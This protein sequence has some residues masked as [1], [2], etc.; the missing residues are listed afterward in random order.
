MKNIYF[1][2]A[3]TTPMDPDVLEAMLPF[4]T[5]DFGNASSGTHH[6]GSKAKAAVNYFRKKI[7]N[8]INAEEGEI[9]FNSG[10]TEGI[11]TILKGVFDRYHTKGKHIISCKTEHKA[12][13]DCLDYLS[14]IGAEITYISVNSNGMINLQELEDSIRPDT[15]LISFLFINNETGVVFPVEKIGELAEQKKTLFFCDATQA[16]GKTTVDV[17]KIKAAA[18]VFSAHKING[19]K[20]VG[21]LY[22]SRKNPRISFTPLLHGGSQEKQLRPGTL[23]VP[24]IVG[25]AKAVE[26][27]PENNGG[28]EAFS[29]SIVNHLTNNGAVI[30]GRKNGSLFNQ[31]LIP[32]II[33][34]QLPSIK[35]ARLIQLNPNFAFSLGSACNSEQK[36]P[37]HVLTAM[38]L[39]KKEIESSFRISIGK[40]TTKEEVEE[41]IQKFKI[42]A[43]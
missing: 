14:S 17:K 39:T 10:A 9:T 40:T 29:S 18:M 13:L 20:G 12:T 7:A 26:L 28:V 27:I 42:Q 25:F 35:A 30:N 31:H 1:D 6:Y 38:G 11:N 19:P 5:E 32:H 37:S 21:A 33:N 4:F 15:I 22:C 8:A 34:I 2:H 36:D 16:L 41:F 24:G 43:I 3:A 23:N